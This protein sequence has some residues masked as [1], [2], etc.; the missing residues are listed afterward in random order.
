MDIITLIVLSLA[1]W[2]LTSLL[3]SEDGPYDVLV[4]VRIMTRAFSCLWCLSVWLGAAVVLAW[5][6]VPFWTVV[7]SLPLAISGAA[8]MIDRYING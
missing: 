8:I 4:K 7:I 5:Y 3:V 2:R 6:F 1:V